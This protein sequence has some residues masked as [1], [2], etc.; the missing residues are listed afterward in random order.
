MA[1]SQPR[2]SNLSSQQK[3]LIHSSSQ[4][5]FINNKA[6]VVG[7]TYSIRNFPT[8]MKHIRKVGGNRTN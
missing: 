8:S 4:P 2:L 7:K 6:K 3:D 5:S 1:G